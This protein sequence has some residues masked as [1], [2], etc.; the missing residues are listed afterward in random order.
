MGN[1]SEKGLSPIA[2]S[3]LLRARAAAAVTPEQQRALEW[4]Q[5][6]VEMEACSEVIWNARDSLRPRPIIGSREP[7]FSKPIWAGMPSREEL[8]AISKKLVAVIKKQES[9][10]RKKL[11]ALKA[12]APMRWVALSDYPNIEI[13]ESGYARKVKSRKLLQ[14]NIS[15]SGYVSYSVGK[16]KP[17]GAHR[18]VAMAFLPN[19]LN[20]PLVNH[21]DLDRS[22]NHVSNLEWVDAATNLGHTKR[23]AIEAFQRSAA[24]V[25][26]HALDY[27]D[28]PRVQ[29][30]LAKAEAKI[31][32]LADSV[33]DSIDGDHYVLALNRLR[34]RAV[35]S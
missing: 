3:I 19:P 30:A 15:P 7:M 31:N 4:R 12:S 34:S 29:E 33:A 16:G 2:G 32:A 35:N 21:I 10:S 20:L 9:A 25:R 22:H 11:A 6:L 13:S 27:A 1:D 17:I 26:A 14:Q 23:L 18:L 8:R 5:R 28:N 24:I